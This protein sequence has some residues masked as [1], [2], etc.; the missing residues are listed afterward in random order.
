MML[1]HI[2]EVEA[3]DRI[4]Y[5]VRQVLE[6]GEKTTPDLGGSAG[7]REMTRAIIAEL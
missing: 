5:A 2:G 6:K 3:A 4:E 1:R 7:T